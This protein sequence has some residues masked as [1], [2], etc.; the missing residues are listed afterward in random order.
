MCKLFCAAFS[1][2][3]VLL[4]QPKHAKRRYK[5]TAHTGLGGVTVRPKDLRV[6][7]RSGGVRR[8]CATELA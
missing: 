4:A 1:P 7:A 3:C 6:R 8:M 5:Y 2:L